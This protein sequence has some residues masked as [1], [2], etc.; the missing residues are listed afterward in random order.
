M[1]RSNFAHGRRR[2]RTLWPTRGAHNVRTPPDPH[3][4]QLVVAVAIR[5]GR[6]ERGPCEVC[7][8]VEGVEAHIPDPAQPF[9]LSWRCPP[10]MPGRQ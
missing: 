2:W 10:H 5:D 1:M 8:A 3:R 6:L 9:A 4:A 7:Q